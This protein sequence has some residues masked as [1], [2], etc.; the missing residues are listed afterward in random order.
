MFQ[1]CG[2]GLTRDVL[3]GV[4][5]APRLRRSCLFDLHLHRATTGLR[6]WIASLPPHMAIMVV[7]LILHSSRPASPRFL[8]QTQTCSISSNPG[9]CRV[10]P[11]TY[12]THD[13]VTYDVLTLTC[14]HTTRKDKKCEVIYV[15]IYYIYI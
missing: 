6:T 5:S 3:C 9:V 11:L 2:Q 13:L 4:W 14:I 10:S 1:N 15:N 8:T 7:R 12:T